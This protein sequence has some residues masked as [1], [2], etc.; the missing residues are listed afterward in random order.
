MDTAKGFWTHSMQ[1]EEVGLLYLR[2]L[3]QASV[4]GCDECARS[5][6]AQPCREVVLEFSIFLM[7]PV[8]YSFDVQEHVKH[9]I[10][11]LFC[12]AQAFDRAALGQ[13]LME[14]DA[15]LEVLTTRFALS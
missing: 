1:F 11:Q 7:R 8:G 10:E 2:E 15:R 13:S 5:W 12:L 6:L 3:I 9:T 4:T 14:Q